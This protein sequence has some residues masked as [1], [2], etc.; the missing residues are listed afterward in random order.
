MA[1]ELS[2]VRVLHSVAVFLNAS[3]NWIYPLITRIP[4]VETRVTC[5][6][7]AN[8]DV[9][10]VS[11]GQV[12]VSPPSWRR[13][14]GLPRFF[15]SVAQRLGWRDAIAALRILPWRPQLVHA[16]FGA[17]GWEAL[18]LKALFRVPLVTSFYGFDA[19]LLPE[20]EPEW[21]HR[22]RTLFAKG[23]AFFVEGAAMRQRLIDLGCAVSKVITQ[24]IGVDLDELPFAEPSFA[25]GLRIA[26]AGR[27]IEKKGL[28]DGLRACAL[29]RAQGVDLRVSVIGDAPATDAKGQ[30]IKAQLQ[31]LAAGPELAG[32]VEFTGFIPRDRLHAVLRAHNVF[33]C[34]S[35]HTADGDA[36]GGSPVVLTEAMALGL[37]CVG[38]KHCDI[39]E[40]IVDGRTGYLSAEADCAALAETLS[41][42]AANQGLAIAFS[43]AGRSHIAECFSLKTQLLQMHRHYADLRLRQPRSMIASTT[44]A[45]VS[46]S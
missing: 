14:L 4:S 3:E 9:F 29:A 17:R 30:R 16:H 10:A 1:T 35:R 33:L 12:I 42:I 22:Y 19:W 15:N 26:L 20:R 44:R 27:F 2:G 21:R 41:S 40:V 25:G 28:S 37:V 45:N 7:V 38:T 32:R 18:Q 23:D 24:R 43:R 5:R 6:G 13:A 8:A 34:P 46:G 11:N 39:P 36:E 31:A